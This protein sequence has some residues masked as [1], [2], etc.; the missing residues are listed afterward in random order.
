MGASTSRPAPDRWRRQGG[1]SQQAARARARARTA[2][3]EHAAAASKAAATTTCPPP[4]PLSPALSAAL[5][6]IAAGRSGPATLAAWEADHDTLLTAV[7]ALTAAVGSAGGRIPAVPSGPA[8]ALP[9]EDQGTRAVAAAVA[10]GRTLD[11]ERAMHALCARLKQTPAA[12]EARAGELGWDAGFIQRRAAALRA[13]LDASDGAAAG[14]DG[15]ARV[16]DQGCASLTVD[17]RTLRTPSATLHCLVM[18]DVFPGPPPA[19]L[20]LTRETDLVRAWNPFCTVGA[21][22]DAAPHPG[23]AR[24]G[25]AAMRV[26]PP[27]PT[28]DLCV[29]GVGHDCSRDRGTAAVTLGQAAADESVPPPSDPPVRHPAEPPSSAGCHRVTLHP[30]SGLLFLPLPPDPVTGRA[31]TLGTLSACMHLHLPLVPAFLV[32]WVVTFVLPLLA[33]N[34]KKHVAGP[35][36]HPSGGEATS[37]PAAAPPPAS[38]RAT[39]TTTLRSRLSPRPPAPSKISADT[40]GLFADRMAASF[41]YREFEE[42]V[43][44]AVAGGGLWPEGADAEEAWLAEVRRTGRLVRGLDES[45]DDR[46]EAGQGVVGGR[47]G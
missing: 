12:L 28:F 27:F 29:R 9:R 23:W 22:L 20:A 41:T 16:V 21:T 24:V 44:A 46:A 7:R 38:P 13:L 37:S 36:F 30:G 47:A 25:Y 43:A 45:C 31:R 2:S 8:A 5:A 34:L 11:A 35:W 3:T 18:N 32:K 39:T 6:A 26:L 42:G 33:R 15:W 14:S 40:P 1:L 17:Y 19:L 4:P 10:S